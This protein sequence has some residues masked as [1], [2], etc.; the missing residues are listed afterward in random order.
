MFSKLQLFFVV[1]VISL[2]LIQ[3]LLNI[4][5]AGLKDLVKTLTLHLQ[6][7]HASRHSVRV[8][9]RGVPLLGG[10]LVSAPPPLPLQQE[11]FSEVWPAMPLLGS[12]LTR[13]R[14]MVQ[15]QRLLQVLETMGEP[16]PTDW[17]APKMY[18]HLTWVYLAFALTWAVLGLM[19]IIAS[20]RRKYCSTHFAS[21]SSRR[22]VAM[23]ASTTPSDSTS[24]ASS[25]CPPTDL[26]SLAA[27]AEEAGINVVC[28]HLTVIRITAVKNLL[29]QGAFGCVY[30][31][32]RD[33]YP[34]SVPCA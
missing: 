19:I 22:K 4:E 28:F 31:L 18:P 16:L 30:S 21:S 32:P 33:V 7:A 25:V 15:V 12:F 13:Y 10:T 1:W 29:G 23:F 8:L 6:K 9:L 26:A 11:E 20:C 5:N 14:R 34:T 17:E 27:R 2:V 3:W 24:D